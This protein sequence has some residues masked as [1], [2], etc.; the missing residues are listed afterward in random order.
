[1]LADPA[2]IDQKAVRLWARQKVSGGGPCGTRSS[3]EC[4]ITRKAR[5]YRSRSGAGA[6]GVHWTECEVGPPNIL[7]SGALPASGSEGDF[8]LGKRNI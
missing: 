3:P 1:M 8:G 6:A 2:G 7:S 4:W 5:D